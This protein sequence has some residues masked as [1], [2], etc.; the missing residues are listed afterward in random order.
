MP[1]P[2]LSRQSLAVL[3]MA[4]AAGLALAGPEA[5][6][7]GERLAQAVYDRPDGKDMSVRAVMLLT[8]HGRSP[9]VRELH[10]Y[11]LRRGPEQVWSLIR[12]TSP[13][14]VNDTGLLTLDHAGAETDQWLYLPALDRARRIPSARKGGR[15]VGSDFYYEDLRDRTPDMD[16]HRLLGDE[17]L[18][19]RPVQVL[20]SVPV[21]PDNSVYSRRLSW[22]DSERL[23]PLRVEFFVAGRDEPAKRLQVHA[24]EQVQ[25]YWTV[26]DSTMT[27]LQSAHETQIAVEAIQYDRGLPFTF[28]SRQTLEDPA[29]EA[30]YR[31]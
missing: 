9:R 8:E 1:S 12:F 18:D 5:E 15:F 25:G 26:M 11:R 24:V 17:E 16:H 31:L 23:L 3:L 22:I 4:L 2:L 14:D 28:F 20:E 6:E 19:G 27:D 13:A 30:S 29:R 21:D 10:T 7:Q